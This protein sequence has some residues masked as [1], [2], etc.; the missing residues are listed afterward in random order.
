MARMA[1]RGYDLVL[2]LN[3]LDFDCRFTVALV[4]Y[5]DKTTISYIILMWI[6]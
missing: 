2:G 5:E 1:D 3:C 4:L 6:L